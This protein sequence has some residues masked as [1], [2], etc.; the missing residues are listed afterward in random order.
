MDHLPKPFDRLLSIRKDERL[1]ACWHAQ[2]VLL[3]ASGRLH[4][5]FFVRGSELE[6]DV[7]QGLLLLTDKGLAYVRV[8]GLV[9]FEQL[10]S[11][12]PIPYGHLL[13][14]GV[15]RYPADL[16]PALRL[17]AQRG[18]AGTDSSEAW[19]PGPGAMDLLFVVG[20]DENVESVASAI[21]NVA[22]LDP[23]TTA[24]SV[25][26]DARPLRSG[27]ADGAVLFRAEADP[28]E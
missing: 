23:L 19:P 24:P 4:S 26:R 16:R 9:G 13:G 20:R 5:G 11:Y 14:A 28:D 25:E 7:R 8:R 17:R 27:D 2:Y 1:L 12:P 18:G 3:D 21:R 6:I 22:G 10:K 15:A